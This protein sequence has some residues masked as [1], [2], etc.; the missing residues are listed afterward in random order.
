VPAQA[1]AKMS[2]GSMCPPPLPCG[3]AATIN[4]RARSKTGLGS[5]ILLERT[6]GKKT[7][8]YAPQMRPHFMAKL[9]KKGTKSYVLT[10]SK[11]NIWRR[12]LPIYTM[13]CGKLLAACYIDFMG[14]SQ[15]QRLGE[16]VLLPCGAALPNRFAK[17][18]MTEQMADPA[19]NAPNDA[20][21]RL[22]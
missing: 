1:R 19:V 6:L 18:A 14:H 9:L 16:T 3:R 7:P 21:I 22:Y 17:A 15:A 5:A 10:A 8:K 2:P 4:T 12:L 13:S 11:V 20:I